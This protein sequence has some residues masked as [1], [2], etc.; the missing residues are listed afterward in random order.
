MDTGGNMRVD[1]LQ[2]QREIWL[3]A[4]QVRVERE[5]EAAR[6]AE[7]M[8]GD[9]AAAKAR[10]EQEFTALSEMVESQS[11]KLRRNLLTAEEIAEEEA[12]NAVLQ[13]GTIE[14]IV[15][16]LFGKPATVPDLEAYE[17]ARV[18]RERA[19]PPTPRTEE[20]AP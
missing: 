15:G 11:D 19:G 17:A 2:T 7:R 10:E 13:P 18:E 1:P 16:T 5:D 12:R 9:V 8:A 6:S 4:R 14:P 20:R 3:K